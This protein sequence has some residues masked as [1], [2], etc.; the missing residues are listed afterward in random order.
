MSAVARAREAADRLVHLLEGRAP[1]PVDRRVRSMARWAARRTQRMAGRLEGLAYRLE[2]RRPDPD[3]D[4]ARLAQRVRSALGPLQKQLDVPRVRVTV[5]RGI[6]ELDGS[7]D[8]DEQARR[9][10][11][12]AERV[13]GIRGVRSRLHVGLRPGDTRPSEGRAVTPRSTAWK[14]LV[15]AARGVGLSDDGAERVAQAVLATLLQCVP[16]EERAHVLAHL[17]ADVRRRTAPP[18]EVGRLVRPRTVEQFDTAVCERARLS[19]GDAAL[20]TRAVLDAVR[21]LVPEE[22]EDVEAVL[23]A[24]LKA[25]WREPTTAS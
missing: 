6:A 4:D 20:A 19:A 16:P 11:R 10:E 8:G 2:G 3:V 24:G 14:E 13:A 22:I 5:R 17:P 23:P 12:A 18:L 25:L 15:G 1:A 7:V 21:T 9:L